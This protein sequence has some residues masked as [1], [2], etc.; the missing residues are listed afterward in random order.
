MHGLVTSS[1][2]MFREEDGERAPGAK[3]AD[4]FIG[5]AREVIR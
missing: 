3:L 5:E 4:S 1:G 2:A